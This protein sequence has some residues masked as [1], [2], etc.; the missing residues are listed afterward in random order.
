MQEPTDVPNDPYGFNL[1]N[2]LTSRAE[3]LYMACAY[4]LRTT[5]SIDLSVWRQAFSTAAYEV[6]R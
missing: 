1:Y 3:R 6:K 2:M 4:P 5:L